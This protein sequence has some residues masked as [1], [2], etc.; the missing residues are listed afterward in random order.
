MAPPVVRAGSLGPA[1]ALEDHHP[2]THRQAAGGPSTRASHVPTS[3]RGPL[4][5][6][7]RSR[8]TCLLGPGSALPLGPAGRVTPARG[9]QHQPHGNQVTQAPTAAAAGAAFLPGWQEQGRC[10]ARRRPPARR[11]P[12]TRMG[13]GSRGGSRSPPSPL[14]I[15]QQTEAGD[16]V[17]PP[18]ETS[19]TDAG[20]AGK[21]DLGPRRGGPT[22]ERMGLYGGRR[23][24]RH[25]QTLVRDAC[26]FSVWLAHGCPWS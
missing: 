7:P 26:G 15:G 10:S 2:E 21:R 6:G 5:M 25:P 17:L 18:S 22:P 11:G 13:S 23:G 1:G 12:E 20:A 14:E 8:Q 19:G 4:L 9:T 3:R 24:P 16:A